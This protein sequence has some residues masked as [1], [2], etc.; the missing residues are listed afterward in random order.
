MNQSELISE[1][2][3]V[4]SL[5]MSFLIGYCIGEFKS[6]LKSNRGTKHV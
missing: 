2:L 4:F 3:L 5:G 1:I 6:E